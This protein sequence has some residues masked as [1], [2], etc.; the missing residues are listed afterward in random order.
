MIRME[1]PEIRP[2]LSRTIPRYC[3]WRRLAASNDAPTPPT[4]TII[5]STPTPLGSRPYRS[6]AKTGI[7]I[8]NGIDSNASITL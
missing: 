7:S 1:T 3:P 8:R 6:F 4:P 2:A 5:A